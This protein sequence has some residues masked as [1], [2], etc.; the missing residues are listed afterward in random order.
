MYASALAALGMAPGTG[1]TLVVVDLTSEFAVPGGVFC[2]MPAA[3]QG[4]IE[5][6]IADMNQWPGA[7]WTICDEHPDGIGIHPGEPPHG[8][9]GDPAA[10][11]LPQLAPHRR[12]VKRGQSGAPA[13]RDHL[14]GPAVIAGVRL[15][16]CVL[17]TAI[18]L[19]QV[20]YPVAVAAPWCWDWYGRDIAHAARVLSRARIPVVG[21]WNRPWLRNDDLPAAPSLLLQGVTC[22]DPQTHVR[23]DVG[24]D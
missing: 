17:R 14:T 23:S 6:A 8:R 20:G 18:G 10:E 21:R 5:E 19:A 7:I 13:V 22:R 15:S 12:L 4:E 11:P 24:A 16:R 1:L 2:P 3:R 9:P